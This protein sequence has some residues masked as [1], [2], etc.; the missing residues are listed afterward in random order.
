MK[1]IT[2]TILTVLILAVS[3]LPLTAFAWNDPE[4]MLNASYNADKK[5][6]TVECTKVKI[7]FIVR[8]I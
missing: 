6:I 7:N 2:A 1:K 3:L 8:K 5:T 4:L